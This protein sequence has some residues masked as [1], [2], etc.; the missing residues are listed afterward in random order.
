MKISDDIHYVNSL[1]CDE[2]TRILRAIGQDLNPLLPTRVEIQ[3]I[4]IVYVING[5]CKR[6]RIEPKKAKSKGAAV[7]TL[8]G[9]WTKGAAVVNEKSPQSPYIEFSRA[10]GPDEIDQL[11]A[12]GQKYR[13][14][15]A[16]IPDARSLGEALRTVG[17]LLDASEAQFVSLVRDAETVEVGYIDRNGQTRTEQLKHHDLY[18]LQQ[19]YYHNRGR[20]EAKDLWGGRP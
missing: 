9:K 8:V 13:T 17:R 19:S 15:M 18:K 1:P 20:F 3:R 5:R 4:G 2:Q 7:R 11:D 10:Y 16:R 6:T 12:K 14:G